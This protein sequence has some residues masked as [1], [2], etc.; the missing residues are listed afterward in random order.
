LRKL[1]A[2]PVPPTPRDAAPA[3]DA[4]ASAS[5]I[6]ASPAQIEDS[7]QWPYKKWDSAKAYFFR[8]PP[9]PH[10]YTQRRGWARNLK[11]KSSL[12]ESASREALS[13]LELTQGS[14]TEVR[15]PIP[16]HGVVFFAG[17]QPVGSISLELDHN[18]VFCWP[19]F[20]RDSDDEAR[21]DAME[22]EISRRAP[23]TFKRWRRLVIDQLGLP[24]PPSKAR[25]KK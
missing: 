16:T 8:G 18:V 14:F 12:D 17:D 15:T 2:A 21:R 10:L 6:D 24:S 23:Q 22:D 13:L 4:S 11:K 9:F 20:A 7:D 3:Y 5:T 19:S 25:K 1:D